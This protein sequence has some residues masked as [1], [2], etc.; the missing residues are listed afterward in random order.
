MGDESFLKVAFC[1]NILCLESQ[2]LKSKGLANGEGWRVCLRLDRSEQ[3]LG[4][5]ACSTAEIEVGGYLATQFLDRPCAF[6]TFRFV[7]ESG[8]GI[9]LGHDLTNVRERKLG[10]NLICRGYE[11][12]RR[13]RTFL[14]YNII[15]LVRCC[16]NFFRNSVNLTSNGSQL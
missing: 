10:K 4:I 7:E 16:R 8:Q 5:L 13:C 15:E 3:L 6:N 14:R 1:N 2:K 9:F 12:V 11:L